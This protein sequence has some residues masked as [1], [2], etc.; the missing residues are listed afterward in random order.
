MKQLAASI[1][2][3]NFG[4]LSAQI[5]E[6]VSAGLDILHL[7]VMDGNF[8]PN[9]TFGADLIR[10][11]R[12]DFSIPFD[13]HLMIEN[14]QKYVA[15]FIQA[16]ADWLSFHWEALPEEEKCLQ[17]LRTIKTKNVRCGLAISP[18]TKVEKLEP[19]FA[20][21]DF[22][23]V[24]TVN[25]G[26]GGQTLLPECLAKI[27]QIQTMMEQQKIKIPIEVDGGVKA[28]NIEQV[29]KT[30]ADIVVAGSAVFNKKQSVAK[31]LKNL[32]QKINNS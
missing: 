13:V 26:F 11:I 19:F 5:K 30:G 29:V 16:G 32:Q 6:A 31:N 22:I 28:E 7:D 14:P 25:P 9:L 18:P 17:L 3:A 1:L 23:V 27:G 10:S 20:E 12:P 21:L 4:C 24:M 8:V 2:T 15:D